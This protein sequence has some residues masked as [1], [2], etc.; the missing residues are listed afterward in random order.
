[1]SGE[2]RGLRNRRLVAG[3]RRRQ[4]AADKGGGQHARQADLEQDRVDGRRSRCAGQRR[5]QRLQHLA[6][7]DLVGPT[8]LPAS[9]ATSRHRARRARTRPARMAPSVAVPPSSRAELI[10]GHGHAVEQ[11]VELPR[12]G[13]EVEIGL[14]G[15][16][17]RQQPAQADQPVERR[18]RIDP[19]PGQ[20]GCQVDALVRDGAHLVPAGLGRHAVE[21]AAVQGDHDVG[22]PGDDLFQRG[23]GDVAAAAQALGHVDG[24]GAL[25][26][27]GVDRAAAAGLQALRGR[28][29]DRRAGACRWAR[30]PARRRPGRRP[31][32]HRPPAR[33]RARSCPASRPRASARRRSTAKRPSIRA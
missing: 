3:A 2:T 17:G 22:L 26:D 24:A 11:V 8:T 32:R 33:R 5:D 13:P 15:I 9:M 21:E 16:E 30:A 14:G 12:L 31:P 1:M 10:V 7:R 23:V 4:C 19:A 25:D 27:L 6:G 20:A 28:A 18:R 29:R